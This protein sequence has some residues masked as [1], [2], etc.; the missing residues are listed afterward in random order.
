MR[1]PSRGHLPRGAEGWSTAGDVGKARDPRGAGGEAGGAER[2]ERW[3]RT[4]PACASGAYRRGRVLL[5]AC[6][7][8][9]CLRRDGATSQAPLI[10]TTVLADLS[11]GPQRLV[12]L[13]PR[14]R[15]SWV[16][17]QTRRSV[18]SPR[19]D[20]SLQEPENSRAGGF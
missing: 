11:R 7:V 5:G 19:D 14:S 20:V 9:Y 8:S 12:E 3:R 4:E 18:I 17:I 15:A 1:E 16:R 6:P 10:Q 2:K 13:S